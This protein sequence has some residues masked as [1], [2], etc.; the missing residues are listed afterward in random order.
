[1]AAKHNNT[2]GT[3]GSFSSKTSVQNLSLEEMVEKLAKLTNQLSLDLQNGI[4]YYEHSFEKLVL[5]IDSIIIFISC[6]LPRLKI[7]VVTFMSNSLKK[8]IN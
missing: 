8:L 3:K 1:M 5:G 7:H 4:D 6:S 2:L